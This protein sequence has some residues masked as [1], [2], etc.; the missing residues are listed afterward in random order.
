[1]SN[2]DDVLL[3]LAER[4]ESNLQCNGMEVIMMDHRSLMREEYALGKSIIKKSIPSLVEGTSFYCHFKNVLDKLNVI[5]PTVYNNLHRVSAFGYSF[6][7][8]IHELR[9]VKDNQDIVGLASATFFA[10]AYVLDH[11]TDEIPGGGQV[12]LSMNKDF[13]HLIF[14]KSRSYSYEE[15][16]SHL[17]KS[18]TFYDDIL[19]GFFL[20]FVSCCQIGYRLNQNS[21][22]NETS[23]QNLLES[24]S[25][26]HFGEKKSS[27]P[28]AGIGVIGIKSI[29][30]FVN[31]FLISKLFCNSSANDPQIN[32][33]CIT[34]GKIF[35]LIDDLADYRRDMATG[36]PNYI[37]LKISNGVS[38]EK[39][40]IDTIFE[41][42]TLLLDSS[43][44]L[45]EIKAS[46]LLYRKA[47]G[48]IYSYVLSW[49]NISSLLSRLGRS[50]SAGSLRQEE[51]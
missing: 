13:L 6:G 11:I 3:K 18:L 21:I 36:H 45:N 41:I 30:P 8:L 17:Q 5:S 38:K 34:I 7:S 51:N 37:N 27:Q 40:L 49:M 16:K 35:W 42:D 31:L 39:A 20:S 46:S 19:L 25:R 33:F 22:E 12:Y 32:E 43:K 44:I 15:I 24:T 47:L 29:E 10:S 48:L 14:D 4:I 26:L 28:E 1:M 2:S 23:W 9:G 50:I